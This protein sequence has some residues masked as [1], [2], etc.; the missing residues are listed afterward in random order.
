MTSCFSN[1]PMALDESTMRLF[2]G[3]RRPA[4]LAVIDTKPG[5]P[6]AQTNASPKGR[7][8]G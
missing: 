1:Y 6:V 2:V 8:S 7:R 3:N 5:M 4:Q